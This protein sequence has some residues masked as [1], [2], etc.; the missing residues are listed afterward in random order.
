[1]SQLTLS[2]PIQGLK[3]GSQSAGTDAAFLMSLTNLLVNE[4]KIYD[5]SYLK[6]RTNAP[7]LINTNGYYAR[8]QIRASHSFGIRNPEKRKHLMTTLYRTSP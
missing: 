8:D 2:V 4:Y 1:M 6:K 5:E 7:Y 3:S